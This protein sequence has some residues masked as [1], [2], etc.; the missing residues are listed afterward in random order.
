[1]RLQAF[2]TESKQDS[3]TWSEMEASLFPAHEYGNRIVMNIFRSDEFPLCKHGENNFKDQ[4]VASNIKVSYRQTVFSDIS[5]ITFYLN[6]K[7]IFDF[8]QRTKQ[9]FR[10]RFKV[11]F[12]KFSKR[13]GRN[14]S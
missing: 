7:T 2:H 13:L 4:T 11:T 10:V 8:C 14:F 6:S 9:Y 3:S 1:M 5:A 12:R